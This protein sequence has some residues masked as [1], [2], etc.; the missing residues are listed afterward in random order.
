[1]TLDPNVQ[2]VVDAGSELIVHSS[3][4]TYGAGSQI[5]QDGGVVVGTGGDHSNPPA[6]P[7]N[8][9]VTIT[10]QDVVIS[11][12][13]YTD[14]NAW[15]FNVKK[16]GVAVDAGNPI[17][18]SQTSYT[19][20]SAVGSLPA[21]YQ[22]VVFNPYGYSCSSPVN[23][24]VA[25][26]TISGS[27]TWSGAVWIN[28]PVTVNSGVTLNVA[29]GTN[30]VLS[31]G[32][33]YAISCNGRLNVQGISGWPITFTSNSGS[34]APGNWGSIIMNGSGANGSSISYANIQYGT[35]VDITSASNVTIQNCSIANNSGHGINLT[36]AS[37][38][39]MQSNTITNTNANH[40]IYI[41]GG[42]NNNCYNNIIYKTNQ[43]HCG[44]GIL[45]NGSSGNVGENDIDYFNWGIAA[46]WGA[47]PNADPFPAVKNN[48][49]TNCL[50]G[51]NVYYQSYCDFGNPPGT[52]Y[53]GNSIHDNNTYNAAVG[54]SYP[55]VASGLYAC[56]DYWGSN[57]P[58]SSKFYVNSAP[59]SYFSHNPYEYT[60]LWQ[61]WPL[62]SVEATGVAKG[63]IIASVVPGSHSETV[64]LS[65][66][67]TPCLTTSTDSLFTGIQLRSG[68]KFGEATA[69]F[70]SYLNRHPD[71]QAAYVDLYS[72]ADS[73]TTPSILQYFNS[74]PSQAA[75]E[76]K[77]LLSNLYLMQGDASNAKRVNN[78]IMSTNP[79]TTL[80]E[81]AKLNNFNIA[82]YFEN[83]PRMAVAILK[84]VERDADLLTPMEIADAEHALNYYVDPKTGEM[85][86]I[87]PEQNDSE[88]TA[89]ELEQYGLLGNYPN[90]FNPSTNISYNLTIGGHVILRVYDVLGRE[91]KTLVN[92]DESA[93]YH[94]VVFD[95]SRLASGVYFYRLTASGMTQVR[96][97]LLT[98]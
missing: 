75:K 76:H 15:Y 22:V 43:N 61:N 89:N 13:K 8:T 88:S 93:G 55:T 77:L 72:C 14:P 98:K 70:L 25:P 18:L 96:K 47:S 30:V 26:A 81:K 41:T 85:P 5:V 86:N 80:G 66:N 54:Y 23:V 57:P 50:F 19:D 12:D 2:L 83:N 60:D 27:T 78:S 17:P 35:E 87:N 38:C 36:S 59:G 34:P 63:T 32:Y 7:T 67:S 42:S 90:P 31:S 37:N 51:F 1:M 91:V 44:A 28:C 39:T 84:D 46:I 62:P 52:A 69:F 6:P 79:N 53:C 9:A 92:E 16:N 97:M 24:T 29:A 40:G 33:S 48:R 11:W 10:G 21:S 95:A 82:L 49:V 20:A 64:E 58:N 3:N 74:L 65:Q 56:D 45:Y 68:G 4:I 94:S 71:D 73:E